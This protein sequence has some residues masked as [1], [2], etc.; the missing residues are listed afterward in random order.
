MPSSQSGP[1]SGATRTAESLA[2]EQAWRRARG[3]A[4]FPARSE[5]GLKTFARFAPL[6]AIIEPDPVKMALPF[7]LT[8]SGFFDLLGFD[9]TGMDYLNLVDPA[10]RRGAYD[11]VM[12]AMRQPCGLWQSTPT[13]ITGGETAFFELTILPI[14][15]AGAEADHVL[16][17][18]TREKR[19]DGGIPNIERVEHATV[20]HWIDT[21]SGGV[22]D[23]AS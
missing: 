7:R 3:H 6:M 22:P 12:A 23:V 21:G 19:P 8:G 9:L 11:S 1:S 16:I 13:Q 17:F 14:S 5:I 4:R 10:I 2:F 20:W 18:V 15:K